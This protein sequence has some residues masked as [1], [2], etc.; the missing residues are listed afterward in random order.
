[1]LSV[2]NGLYFSFGLTELVRRINKSAVKT[3]NLQLHIGHYIITPTS[4]IRQEVSLNT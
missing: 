4:P 3:L 1:M 2:L